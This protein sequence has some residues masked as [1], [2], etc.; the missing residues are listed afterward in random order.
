MPFRGR[1]I[2][3]AACVGVLLSC[4]RAPSNPTSL[5]GAVARVGST[6]VSAALIA[7]AAVARGIP[8][9][10]AL[11]AIVDDELLAQGAIDG[12]LDRASA[13]VWASSAMLASRLLVHFADAARSAG[14]PTED[15]LSTRLVVHAV[16]LRSASLS[17][18]DALSL[19]SRIEQAVAGAASA[20]EFEDRARSTRSA[21]ARVVVERVGPFS[22]D[23]T[24]ASGGSLDPTFVAAAFSLPAVGQTSPV[25]ETRFGWHVIRLVERVPPD[26]ATV[27]SR[28]SQLANAVLELRARAAVDAL[29]ANRRRRTPIDLESGVDALMAAAFAGVR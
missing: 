11:D 15:E 3:C 6:P 5:G 12:H 18:P 24:T 9:R 28:R 25:V 22:A 4:N 8:P 1:S 13:V 17:S 23:G 19:A 10:R 16:V 27:E 7:T 29:V 21:S 14:R 2:G 20:D 26:P